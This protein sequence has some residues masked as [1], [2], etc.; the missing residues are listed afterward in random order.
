M[1]KFKGLER[2]LKKRTKGRKGHK[3]VKDIRDEKDEK[4]V[5]DIKDIRD[6]KDEKDI[7]DIRDVKDLTNLN[8]DVNDFFTSPKSLR[9]F[10]SFTSYRSFTSLKKKLLRIIV[11]LNFNLIIFYALIQFGRFYSFLLFLLSFCSPHQS[12]NERKRVL[13]R[14]GSTIKT[15]SNQGA[16]SS[17]LLILFKN[18]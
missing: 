6:E 3:D 2:S 12:R 14:W 18:T 9:S 8:K 4:D 1:R 7:R 16:G 17:F 5:K 10:T 11:R 13:R 15:P